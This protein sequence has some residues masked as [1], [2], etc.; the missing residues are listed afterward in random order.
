MAAALGCL[1]FT[2][3]IAALLYA[4][5]ASLSAALRAELGADR[6]DVVAVHPGSAQQ[7]CRLGERE[8]ITSTDAS[9]AAMIELRRVQE[10]AA[11]RGSLATVSRAAVSVRS[12]GRTA[13]A[14]LIGT[15][16][17]LFVLQAL[18]VRAGRVWTPGEE[19]AGKPIALV[20]RALFDS[21]VPW[22][23][24]AAGAND[25]SAN[26]MAM[27]PLTI[28]IGRTDLDVIGVVE[29]G[30]VSSEQVDRAVLVS[31][32]LFSRLHP[33]G[34]APPTMY[35]RAPAGGAAGSIGLLD[36]LRVLE[37]RIPRFV[38][39]LTV[40]TTADELGDLSLL[41]ES[42]ARGVLG[43][44][45]VLTLSALVAVAALMVTI[46]RSHRRTVGLARA[47]GATRGVVAAQGALIG[48][49]VAGA[50]VACG[51]LLAAVGMSLLTRIADL[52]AVTLA[53]AF[54]AFA[55]GAGPPMLA[56]V[57]TGTVTFA[58]LA[59]LRPARLLG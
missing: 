49:M 27:P 19:T 28:R 56:S 45:V 51:G 10:P 18:A 55:R 3:G 23:R 59:W 29:S 7:P 52:P 57:V 43:L 48:V 5:V 8:C 11:Q 41:E 14:E 30:A 26:V 13:R 17:A 53:D 54:A 20:G 35:A 4:G 9:A 6:W 24:A 42:L 31:R 33:W 15:H 2:A 21:L 25:A 16:A 22:R 34:T 38:G 39:Q 47:M 36:A 32:A 1:A 58:R 40:R 50:G 46:A 12:L 37:R 44:S